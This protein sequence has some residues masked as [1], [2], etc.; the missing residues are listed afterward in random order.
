MAVV[1]N[2]DDWVTLRNRGD[3]PDPHPSPFPVFTVNGR[4]PRATRPDP[5]IAS[6]RVA[7][8]FIRQTVRQLRQLRNAAATGAAGTGPRAKV[9]CQAI[10]DG[11]DEYLADLFDDEP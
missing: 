4:G 1:V 11:V 2:R 5:A 3:A 10:A 8:P 6:V 7:V 9:I